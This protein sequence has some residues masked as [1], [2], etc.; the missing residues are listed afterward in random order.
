RPHIYNT[1]LRFSSS[2][3]KHSFDEVFR[4]RARNQNAGI[5]EQRQAVELDRA[6]DV[7]NGFMNFAARKKSLKLLVLILRE[8]VVGIREEKSPGPLNRIYEQKLRVQA[9]GRIN[10]RPL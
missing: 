5:Y 10:F 1:D 9:R 8:N 7:L 4:L 6:K 2:L 3:F